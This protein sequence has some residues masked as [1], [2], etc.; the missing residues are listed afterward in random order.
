MTHLKG[1][2]HKNH[3]FESSCLLSVV[4]YGGHLCL[5]S[6][7]K[8]G[9]AG[10]WTQGKLIVSPA[11]EHAVYSL[12]KGETE[13]SWQEAQVRLRRS[14]QQPCA[15]GEPPH[16]VAFRLHGLGCEQSYSPPSTVL[17]GTPNHPRGWKS[18]GLGSCPLVRRDKA[19]ASHRGMSK[20]EM[21][22]ASSAT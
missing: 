3:A 12:K 18:L 8:K 9:P 1:S 13:L 14:G 15:L 19:L 22:R 7:P 17:L 5:L 6:S 4:V 10:P 2:L 11:W 20:S 21:Q 16:C